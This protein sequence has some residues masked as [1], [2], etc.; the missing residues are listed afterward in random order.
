MKNKYY[1]PEDLAF[2]AIYGGA[3]YERSDTCVPDP[4]ALPGGSAGE[5]P[6]MV[7]VLTGET[8]F[9][10]RLNAAA[11][12]DVELYRLRILEKPNYD[13]VFWPVDLMILSPALQTRCTI[14]VDNQYT[15][16][17]LP[18]EA[19]QGDLAAAFLYR[20]M[21]GFERFDHWL[22]HAGPLSWKNPAIIKASAAIIRAVGR[23]NRSGYTFNDFHFSRFFYN[24][25]GKL[26]LDYST[27]INSKREMASRTPLRMP[28]ESNYPLEFAYP[29][30][31]EGSQRYV[32]PQSQNYSLAAMLFYL[33]FGRFAYDGRLMTGYIDADVLSHYVKFRQYHKVAFFIFDPKSDRNSIGAFFEEKEVIDLWNECPQLL[34]GNFCDALVL[35]EN[36]DSGARRLPLP[37]PMSWLSALEKS[38]LL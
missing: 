26:M 9:L 28:Y 33:Y 17:P 36:E 22:A 16:K 37:T 25:A 4:F 14:F 30:I 31:I 7:N 38:G 20:D 35:P 24:D 27:L 21:T 15:D 5:S 32:T 12:K 23:L 3:I 2:S 34:R 13:G 1:G 19:R 6:L 18:R 8:M 10:R 29:Q 11:S